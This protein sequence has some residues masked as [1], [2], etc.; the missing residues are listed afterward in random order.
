[1]RSPQSI[2]LAHACN[3]KRLARKASEKN[4]VV[5]NVFGGDF[6]NVAHQ[7][8]VSPEICEYVFCAQGFHSLVKMHFP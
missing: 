7:R 8:L 5:R 6:G 2:L 1:M 3:G 4:I